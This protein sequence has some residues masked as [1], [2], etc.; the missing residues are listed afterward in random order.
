MVHRHPIVL[1]FCGRRALKEFTFM[2][3]SMITMSDG[4]IVRMYANMEMKAILHWLHPL[5][6]CLNLQH[7]T[8]FQFWNWDRKFVVNRYDIRTLYYHFLDAQ[9]SLNTRDSEHEIPNS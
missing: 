6:K 5:Q 4:R 3:Y 8:T 7:D 1:K 2:P 9:T